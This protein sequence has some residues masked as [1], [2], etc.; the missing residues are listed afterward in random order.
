MPPVSPQGSRSAMVAWTVIASVLWLTA[1][2]FAIYFYVNANKVEQNLSDLKKRYDDVIAE[3][4]LAGADV[5]DLKELRKDEAQGFTAS[6]KL[7]DVVKLQ[8]DRLAKLVAGG[9]QS[10]SVASAA[11]KRS[12]A[13]AANNLKTA[14]S[15]IA[16]PTT[17]NLA[18]AVTTLSNGLVSQITASKNLEAQ[19]NESKNQNK[20]QLEQFDAARKTMDETIAAVTADKDKAVAEVATYKSTKDQSVA[21]IQT[22][23]DQERTAA[24]EA[25]Q[26]GSVAIAERDR[27]ITKLQSDLQ[28]AQTRLGGLRVDVKGPIIRNPDG[29]I[30]RVPGKDVCYINLGSGDS[31]TP[32]LTF[33]V[34]DK[35]DG[36][37]ANAEGTTDENLPAGKASIEV[38]RVGAGSSECRIIKIAPGQQLTEGDLIINLIY[39]PA[40]KYNF[41]I[42]GDFDLDQNGQATPADAEVVKRLITQWGGRLI[43]RKLTIRKD[44]SSVYEISVDTDFVILGKEPVLPPF[45]KDELADPFNQKKLSDAQAALD[46]YQ[47]VVRSARDL[48]IPLMNQNRFLYFIGYYDQSKR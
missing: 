26:K 28:Q 45:N 8:R 24:Q 41:M 2:I 14:G 5:A 10:E 25:Q 17:D 36:I 4:S 47:D 1:T 33:E 35:M 22:A 44:G 46:A 30:I 3:G 21:E 18:L 31:I 27:T 40:T 23:M 11:A 38:A 15:T 34:F 48:H 9:T 12:L 39:D 16:V 32:G 19:L 42:Y 20:A 43:D 6:T 29:K 13:D 37:P 7:F